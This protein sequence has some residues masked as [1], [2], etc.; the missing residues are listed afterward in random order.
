[1]PVLNLL[2]PGIERLVRKGSADR[3]GAG[4]CDPRGL[5]SRMREARLHLGSGG[6]W[7]MIFVAMSAAGGVGDTH[8]GQ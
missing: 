5:R 6:L 8:R 1:M 3:F 2:V 7:T 4:R